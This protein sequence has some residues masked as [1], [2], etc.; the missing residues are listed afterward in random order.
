MFDHFQLV[1]IFPQRSESMTSLANNASPDITY[2]QSISREAEEG[3]FS[4]RTVFKSLK[5]SPVLP[6]FLNQLSS[7][8]GRWFQTSAEPERW[9]ASLVSSSSLRVSAQI[10]KAEAKRFTTDG[11]RL[12]G[13]ILLPPSIAHQIFDLS[14]QLEGVLVCY[15]LLSA[16]PDVNS[17]VG[18]VVLII[19]FLGVNKDRGRQ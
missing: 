19:P 4:D 18:L 14:L 11:A 15:Q 17:S 2:H 7:T 10:S 16:C 8:P 5:T 6:R 3:S 12:N 1:L 13:R 9:R